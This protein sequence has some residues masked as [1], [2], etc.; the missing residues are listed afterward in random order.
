MEGEA[1]EKALIGEVIGNIYKTN[2]TAISNEMED[3]K[4]GKPITKEEAPKGRE[5]DAYKA[6]ATAKRANDVNGMMRAKANLELL[7]ESK[8]KRKYLRLMK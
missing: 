8:L 4:S 1:L 6:F 7:P 5:V 3:K 2:A